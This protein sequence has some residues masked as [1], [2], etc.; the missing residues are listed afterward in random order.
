VTKKVEAEILK[1]REQTLPQDVK[2]A[3]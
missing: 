3:K 1:R 2:T